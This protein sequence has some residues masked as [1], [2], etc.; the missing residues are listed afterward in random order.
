MGRRRRLDA[1]RQAR[2]TRVSARPHRRR[3][4]SLRGGGRPC[5]PATSRGLRTRCCGRAAA[6]CL[7]ILQADISMASIRPRRTPWRSW[8]T[9][10]PISRRFPDFDLSWKLHWRDSSALEGLARPEEALAAYETAVTVVD[11]LRRTP[12]GYRLDSGYLRSKLPLFD[13]AID[14]AERLGAAP[15]CARLIELVKARALSNTLSIPPELRAAR[16][17]R[18]REFDDVS[19]RMDAIEYCSYAGSGTRELRDEHDRLVIH[20]RELVEQEY[21]CATRA[22]LARGACGLSPRPRA[23][24]ARRALP[25][26]AD[27]V[28]ARRSD[29]D[30]AR[31]GQPV[32][33]RVDA[34]LRG[35]ARRARSLLREPPEVA[36]RRRAA[37]LL[38]RLRPRGRRAPLH[39][40]CWRSRSR[41]D[42]C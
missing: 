31:G 30:R 37:R 33:R 24:P 32:Q 1:A 7:R 27:A 41:L 34:D 4:R 38:G 9:R 10:S 35:A 13:A 26:R 21:G 19:R 22:G 5:S 25:G 40:G 11:A 8:T 14:L 16:S 6:A 20:R 42:R 2:G 39:P 3:P 29:R 12:L 18:E 17:D 28:P 23:R 36:A 15:S